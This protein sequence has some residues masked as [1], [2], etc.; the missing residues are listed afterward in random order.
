MLADVRRGRLQSLERM[1]AEFEPLFESLS[2]EEE[3]SLPQSNEVRAKLMTLNKLRAHLLDELKQTRGVTL[4]ELGKVNHGR[5]G[6]QAYRAM[7]DQ[8]GPGNRRGKL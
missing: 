6:L 5:R 8:F 3:K 1:T 4:S 2:S 7:T